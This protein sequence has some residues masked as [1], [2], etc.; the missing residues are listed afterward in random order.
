MNEWLQEQDINRRNDI[1]EKLNKKHPE[2]KSDGNTEYGQLLLKYKRLE[3]AYE[4]LY[5]RYAAACYLYEDATGI[6]LT[7]E[8]DGA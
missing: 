1:Y 5:K 8:E 3:E 6:D 7:E 2:E 4:K